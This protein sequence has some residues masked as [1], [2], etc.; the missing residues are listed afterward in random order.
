MTYCFDLI[1]YHCGFFGTNPLLL[2]GDANRHWRTLDLGVISMIEVL[3]NLGWIDRSLESASTISKS[4]TS[5]AAPHP[6]A[7]VKTYSVLQLA[8]AN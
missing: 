5:W 2:G 1:V 3:D 8:Q 4:L 7:W 6:T